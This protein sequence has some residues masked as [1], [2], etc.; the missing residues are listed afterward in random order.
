MTFKTRKTYFLYSWNREMFWFI[1]APVCVGYLWFHDEEHFVMFPIVCSTG[2]LVCN[3]FCNSWKSENF[4]LFGNDKTRGF[5][6]IWGSEVLRVFSMNFVIWGVIQ[7]KIVFNNSKTHISS[8]FRVG[9]FAKELT[10]FNIAFESSQALQPTYA[11]KKY[12]GIS[13]QCTSVAS[14]SLCCS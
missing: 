7:C 12:H 9:D 3:Y 11:A 5:C 1:T 10:E 6:F 14:C 8:I 2:R 13:S 4:L